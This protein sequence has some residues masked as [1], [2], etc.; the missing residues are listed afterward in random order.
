MR[1]F[2]VDPG[3][4]IM[5]FAVVDII[6]GEPEV[7]DYGAIYTDKGDSHPDRLFE[8]R[9]DLEG[10]LKRFD[11]DVFAI[12]KLYY[13]VN[14][15]TALTVSEA[16]G[17]AISSARS[18]GLQVFEYSPN[19]VKQALT[20]HGHA[21]KSQVQEMVVRQLNLEEVPKPDDVADALAVALC[22]VQHKQF[23]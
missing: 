17:V 12:E 23:I 2:G 16:R 8:I 22:F 13:G 1:V 6:K 20:A 18:E 5:G 14:T 9:T 4:A 3:V 19:Q 21:S 10:L 15:T 11:P 7:C